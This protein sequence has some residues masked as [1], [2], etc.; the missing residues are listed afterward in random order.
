M[1]RRPKNT[2]RSFSEEDEI[3]TFKIT[4]F[5]YNERVALVVLPTVV[6]LLGFGGPLVIGSMTVRAAERIKDEKSFD[7]WVVPGRTSLL[8]K[9]PDRPFAS[10][11]L[12][13]AGYKG[14]CASYVMGHLAIH[15]SWSHVCFLLRCR[16]TVVA[17]Y[18]LFTRT[19]WDS[20]PGLWILGYSAISVDPSSKSGH[21]GGNGRGLVLP[22]THRMSSDSDVGCLHT[23]WSRC[24]A[25][26]PSD[27]YDGL[28]CHLQW[29]P[30]TVYSQEARASTCSLW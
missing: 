28:S 5:Q 22:L 16:T 2:V 13:F 15:E 10:L 8:T 24:S 7:C 1:H 17:T 14:S 19:L 6:L 11:H 18:N 4:P 30:H 3:D 26:L 25:I 9:A 23:Y 12:R 29:I 27:F 21:S 20:S